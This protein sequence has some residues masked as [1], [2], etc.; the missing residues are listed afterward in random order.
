VAVVVSSG[1]TATYRILG[2]WAGPCD[3]TVVWWGDTSSGPTCVR[4]EAEKGRGATNERPEVDD[5]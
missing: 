4:V 5:R 3:G 2:R 1:D